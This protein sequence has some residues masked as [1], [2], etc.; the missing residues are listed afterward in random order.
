MIRLL[1]DSYASLRAPIVL[2]HGLFGF[3][4]LG[5]GPVTL[6]AY[7]R[8]IPELLRAHGYRVLVT[9]V[10]PTAGI[11][12]RA[13]M[14]GRRI[15]AAFPAEPVHLIGHSMGG[16]DARMLLTDP[17]WHDRVLSLTTI[18]T[19]H[20]GSTL[21]T[22]AQR[23]L[24]PVYRLL[25]AVGLDHDGFLDVTPERAHRFH[26]Q[27]GPLPPSIASLSIGGDPLPDRVCWPLR[28]LHRLMER[29]EGR[30]DGLVSV[31]SSEAFGTPLPAWGSDHLQQMN[32]C[33]GT[34]RHRVADDVARSY[35]GLVEHLQRF[36]GS[37]PARRVEPT[38]IE[39]LVPRIG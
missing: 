21:A 36:D 4:R 5:L 38:R 3:H 9:R 7:F 27:L 15:D 23:R 37:T 2:A 22:A 20:L 16:L 19:P 10:H 30:N 17:A 28:S 14:L 13:R 33:T 24:G 26:E 18:A 12:R 29:L 39:S 32:W 11:E 31:A 6:A 35:L 8:G 34:R 1:D 25:R